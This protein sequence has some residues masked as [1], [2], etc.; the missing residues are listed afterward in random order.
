MIKLST[1]KALVSMMEESL[2][3]KFGEVSH[4][5][6]NLLNWAESVSE[7][8]MLEKLVDIKYSRAPIKDWFVSINK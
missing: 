4:L 3:S 2:K 6:K 1:K 5:K 8:E 7:A